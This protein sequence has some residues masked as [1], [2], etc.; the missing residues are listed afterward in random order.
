M[1]RRPPRSTRTDTLFPYTTLFRSQ[2][3]TAEFDYLRRYPPLVN[4]VEQTATA[5][6][7]A[8]ATVGDGLVDGDAEALT[9]A[10]DF[11]FMLEHKPGAYILLGNGGA[12]E[13]GCS[14]VHTPTYDF[15]DEILLTGAD[16]K[17]TRLNSSH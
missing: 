8:Q 3:C 17:S 2:G 5:I 12:E 1:I 13:G 10:E 9:G 15:N 11:A 7:A 16:R 14:Y 6:R 4:A